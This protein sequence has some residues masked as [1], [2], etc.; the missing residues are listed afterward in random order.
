MAGAHSRAC[1]RN[2]VT[3]VQELLGSLA[4]TSARTPCYILRQVNRQAFIAFFSSARSAD[5][6]L[7]LGSIM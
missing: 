3:V 2:L 7:A 5:S 6:S 4:A 1:R